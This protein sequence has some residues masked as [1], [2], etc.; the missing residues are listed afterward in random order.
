MNRECPRS[1]QGNDA[2]WAGFWLRF[3]ALH[4]G[5]WVFKHAA[6]R[7]GLRFKWGS[8]LSSLLLL[9]SATSLRADLA[10]ILAPTLPAS[11]A[12]EVFFTG[13]LSNTSLSD[14][15]FLNNLQ[16]SFTG[17]A[18]NYLS[19][20]TNAFF[21]NVPGI[22][23]PGETYMDVV[24]G[25]LINSAIPPG[26]YTGTVSIFGGDDIFASNSL[27]SQDFEIIWPPLALTWASPAS[28]TYGTALGASQLNA[29]A[30]IAG[31]FAYGPSNGAVLDVGTNLLTVVFTP[32]DTDDYNNAT[33]TVRL[34]VSPAPLTVTAASV[35]RPYGQANPVFQSTIMGLQNG[36]NITANYSCSADMSSPVGNYNIVPSL[37]DP[38]DLQ[39]NYSVTLVNGTL[40]V[41]QAAVAI[42]WVNPDP[43][44]CGTALSGTQLDATASV[45][46]TFSYT[47]T[48]GAILNT[49]TN[50]LFVSF[51][52]TDNIDYSNATDTVSLVVN[53]PFTPEVAG[54]PLLPGWGVPA[55]LAGFLVLGFRFLPKPTV[56]RN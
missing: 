35:S 14:N 15:L 2:E 16:V 29:V 54:E 55:M 12:L 10:F 28:I 8:L 9:L 32:D 24:F 25:V 43:I 36:D 38:G 45:P 11:G 37:N 48:I 6:R 17:T 23:L 1:R 4:A 50:T 47:P 31:S 33:D 49:G 44:T 5:G 42:S 40:A 20:D 52:P 21:A 41:N 13:T 46:G 18:S 53:P 30:N 27:A 19:A 56:S 7:D 22:L 34:V 39:T 51:T 3:P 26:D